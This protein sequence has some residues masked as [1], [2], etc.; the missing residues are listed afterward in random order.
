M[1]PAKLIVYDTKAISTQGDPDGILQS[2][3]YTCFGMNGICGQGGDH[4]SGSDDQLDFGLRFF[5]PVDPRSSRFGMLD[6]WIQN[7]AYSIA[8]RQYFRLW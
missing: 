4:S 6:S 3:G 8:P 7:D 1:E 5:E 2:R